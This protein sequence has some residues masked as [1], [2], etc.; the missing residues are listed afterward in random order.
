M[1]KNEN[2]I[3]KV[4]KGKEVAKFVFT[5]AINRIKIINELCEIEK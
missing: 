1:L 3:F 2:K 4:E 5:N